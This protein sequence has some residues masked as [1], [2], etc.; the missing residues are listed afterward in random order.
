MNSKKKILFF[1]NAD[2]FFVS[3]RLHIANFLS[4]NNFEVHVAPNFNN[5]RKYFNQNIITHDIPFTRSSFNPLIFL[6]EVY[7]TRRWNR[8]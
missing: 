4:S 2:W 6:R 5:H 3:H 7:L 8:N 1:I